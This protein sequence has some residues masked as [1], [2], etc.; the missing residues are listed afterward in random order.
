LE[1]K[2]GESE[3]EVTGHDE[4]P[5]AQWLEEPYVIVVN[6]QTGEVNTASWLVYKEETAGK[7]VMAAFCVAL[8]VTVFAA[9]SYLG[10][11]TKSPLPDGPYQTWIVLSLILAVFL[12]PPLFACWLWQLIK[13]NQL[14]TY[15]RERRYRSPITYTLSS[16]GFQWSTESMTMLSPWTEVSA[17]YELAQSLTLYSDNTII[18]L[19]KRCFASAEQLKKVRK[20][21]IESGVVYSTLGP[22]KADIV[23]SGI[24]LT[25]K[26]NGIEARAEKQEGE[27]AMLSSEATEWQPSAQTLT[28]ECNYSLKE[29]TEVDKK[30]FFKYSLT[31]LGIRYIGF[32]LV[33]YCYSWFMLYILGEETGGE[34]NKI[35]FYC[36][37]LIIPIFLIHARVIFEKK[38]DG[39]R[40]L[41]K[42]DLPVYITLSNDELSIRSRRTLIANPWAN[43][44]NCFATKDHYIC[45]AISVTVII[46]KSALDSHS[47]ELFVENLLR[48][49]IKRYEEW[50]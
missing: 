4:E 30:L 50:S 41:V 38:I 49:K 18:P 46:P 44:F 8:V 32:M 43:Y 22:Q 42:L 29:L 26:T 28:I 47:K 17:C 19:P 20:L 3:T 45:R 36:A 34:F 14:D 25:T 48:T 11:F 13:A 27:S 39:L 5:A 12:V 2:P 9:L 1:G 24:N 6:Y 40:Q 21:I 35:L 23:F 7:L 33:G 10:I 37:P 31:F 15:A 16:A